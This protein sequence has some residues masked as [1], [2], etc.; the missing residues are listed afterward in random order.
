[1]DKDLANTACS[2]VAAMGRRST[3]YRAVLLACT[4]FVIGVGL[5]HQASLDSLSLGS[6]FTMAGLR[7]PALVGEECI[8]NGGGGSGEGV[9]TSV[10][11]KTHHR[12]LLVHAKPQAASMQ[13]REVWRL[14]QPSMPVATDVEPHYIGGLAL[15]K[16]SISSAIKEHLRE[17]KARDDGRLCHLHIILVLPNAIDLVYVLY[18]EA[19]RKFINEDSSDTGQDPTRKEKP[20]QISLRDWSKDELTSVPGS[21]FRGNRPVESPDCCIDQDAADNDISPFV[22]AILHIQSRR[23]KE[24]I[25]AMSRLGCKLTITDGITGTTLPG[26]SVGHYRQQM[27]CLLRASG[28]RLQNAT[29][30]LFH[31]ILK[32]PLRPRMRLEPLENWDLQTHSKVS[33]FFQKHG[34]LEISVHEALANTSLKHDVWVNR[35]KVAAYNCSLAKAM[36]VVFCEHSY[37]RVLLNWMAHY[38]QLRRSNPYL[39]PVLIVSM[40]PDLHTYLEMYYPCSVYLSP[41]PS[42]NMA[43]A[44]WKTRLHVFLWLSRWNF[45][46]I[47]SDVDAV[48]LRNPAPAIMKQLNHA[49]PK[50]RFVFSQDIYPGQQFAKWGATACMGLFAFRGGRKTSKQLETGQGQWM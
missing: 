38:S 9:N 24:Q 36:T 49:V 40:T 44:F 42:L 19:V 16:V 33:I 30:S 43:A 37:V 22:E 45:T 35:L 48:W 17:M 23:W 1:M 2:S 13:A 31:D 34:S 6:I 15:C 41:V 3:L 18:H 27:T 7:D 5:A 12:Y 32:L 50:A 46:V 21:C 4:V 14:L 29:E 8:V 20:R 47:H 10:V 25:S 26:S 28:L 39:P 11:A